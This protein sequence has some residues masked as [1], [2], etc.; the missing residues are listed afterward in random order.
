MPA[1]RAR[2][3]EVDDEEKPA[4]LV[5]ISRPFYM[6]KYEVTQEEYL[7][8]MGNNPSWFKGPKNPVELVSWDDA[9][10]FCKKVSQLTGK[11]VR[12]PTEAQWEY[13]CRAGTKT[14]F[15]TRFYSGDAAGDLDGVAWYEE[16]SRG[17]THPVG[18][19]K[20]NAWD[21]YDLHG[22]VWEWCQDVY[23]PY[24]AGAVMDPEGPA[25][26]TRSRVLRGGAWS[27]YPGGCLPAYRVYD[28]PNHGSYYFGFRIVLAGL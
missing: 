10:E 9:Q 20:P 25:N 19:K 1:A 28:T 4:H 16:N 13:A 2:Y 5:T 22:N 12:L 6:G 26:G 15:W 18:Q 23:G 24:K 21:L 11:T 7:Q 27:Y 8:I 17:T 14:R 3:R